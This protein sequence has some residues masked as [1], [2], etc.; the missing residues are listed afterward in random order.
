MDVHIGSPLSC[1]CCCIIEEHIF[2]P[3]RL[4]WRRAEQSCRACCLFCTNCPADLGSALFCPLLP[5]RF[6]KLRLLRRLCYIIRS[7]LPPTPPLESD[8][9]ACVCPCFFVLVSMSN[10]AA[11]ML[12]FCENW[13]YWALVY[14]LPLFI[15]L[16][17]RLGRRMA[18]SSGNLDRRRYLRA[19]PARSDCTP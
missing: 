4:H 17:T 5:P 2:A 19:R 15:P 16:R 10:D 1:T 13:M 18:P 11:H 14:M 12:S 8:L 7:S 9:L 3:A 6:Y